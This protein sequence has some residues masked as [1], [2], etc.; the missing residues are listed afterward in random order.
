MNSVIE[1]VTRGV[2]MITIPLFAEQK[3][4]AAMVR[5]ARIG[6]TISAADFA[7]PENFAALLSTILKDTRYHYQ[8]MT[9]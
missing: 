5:R 1:T 4:N 6:I 2:P 8:L 9:Q 3:R 7:N